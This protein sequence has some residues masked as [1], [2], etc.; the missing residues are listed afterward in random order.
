MT[1]SYKIE[2]IGNNVTIEYGNMDFGEKAAYGILLC[3]HTPLAGNTVH[4]RFHHEDGTSENRM[5][6][7]VHTEGY[8]EQK[9]EIEPLQGKG[10]IDL[11]F[12]PGSAFDL[13]WIQ[14]V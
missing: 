14:F 12:L 8:A 9:F 4:I 6:E 5:V 13:A 2:G 10:R 1:N 7:F 3:G 11:V